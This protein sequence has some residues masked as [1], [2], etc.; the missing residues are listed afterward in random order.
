MLPDYLKPGLDV[1]FCGTAAGRRS[2]QL[3]HYYAGRGNGFWKVL[4]E[5]GMTPEILKIEQDFRITEFGIGLT[6][7]AGS[8]LREITYSRLEVSNDYLIRTF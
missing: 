3:G 6:D 2:G 1:V 8:G 7:L 5:T 4:Y